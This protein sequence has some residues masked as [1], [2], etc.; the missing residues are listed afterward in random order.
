LHARA[1]RATPRTIFKKKQ[2]A[3]LTRQQQCYKVPVTSTNET[4]RLLVLLFLL[5]L[6]LLLLA[7]TTFAIISNNSERGAFFNKSLKTAG[8]SQKKS[9]GSNEL[10]KKNSVKLSELDRNETS[11]LLVSSLLSRTLSLPPP[12]L[13]SRGARARDHPLARKPKNKRRKPNPWFV[14]GS[15]SVFGEFSHFDDKKYGDLLWAI[16]F[17]SL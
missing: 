10:A 1:E 12:F 11:L 9:K 2:E 7:F 13:L 14:S 4:N 17:S 6:L 8:N 15:V 5:L 3:V 16:F